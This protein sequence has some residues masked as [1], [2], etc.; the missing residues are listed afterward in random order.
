MG[1]D[2]ASTPAGVGGLQADRQVRERCRVAATL[3]LIVSSLM[4]IRDSVASFSISV[5]FDTHDIK[6]VELWGSAVAMLQTD[7][8]LG[9]GG[10]R[11]HKWADQVKG[12]RD[13][14]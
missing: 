4:A 14:D 9:Q 3:D 7:I 13:L 8:V 5:P 10:V 11:Y 6:S 1:C 2:M 12:V